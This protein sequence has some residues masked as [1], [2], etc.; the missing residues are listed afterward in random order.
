MIKIDLII[1]HYSI[2][3]KSIMDDIECIICTE[4]P[5]DCYTT[6]CCHS[7]LCDKCIKQ[8]SICPL[9]R[10][11]LSTVLNVALS[12]IIRQ[13]AEL[14]SAN[15]SDIISFAI[16]LNKY[17]LPTVSNDTKSSCVSS[18]FSDILKDLRYTRQIT[19]HLKLEIL[20]P[21]IC[22]SSLWIKKSNSIMHSTLNIIPCFQD[23]INA[24]THMINTYPDIMKKKLVWLAKYGTAQIDIIFRPGYSKQIICS[25][26]QMCILMSFQDCD[27]LHPVDI[28]RTTSIDIHAVVANLYALCDIQCPILIQDGRYFK[29]NDKFESNELNPINVACTNTNLIIDVSLIDDIMIYKMEN[30]IISITCAHEQIEMK[31]LIHEVYERLQY[32]E[33]EIR[34]RIDSLISR[35]YLQLLTVDSCIYVG[36][37]P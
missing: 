25:T 34:H 12:R 22:N 26:Y 32:P 24:C 8:I 7:I 23:E 4:S 14:Q 5:S 37:I 36:Y 3:I 2:S 20:D 18:Y 27:S 9:C 19:K 31:I 33:H 29:F 30:L 15:D 28:S 13:K 17:R 11:P 6:C 1:Q 21:F 10:I 35:G 16:F